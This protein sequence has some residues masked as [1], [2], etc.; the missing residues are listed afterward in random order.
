MVGETN[1]HILISS[2]ISI[3]FIVC[4]LI[5]CQFVGLLDTK[6]KVQQFL[7]TTLYF[8]I[9]YIYFTFRLVYVPTLLY[10]VFQLHGNKNKVTKI[11]SLLHTGTYF[12]SS[13]EPSIPFLGWS[14]HIEIVCL[15]FLSS[16]LILLSWVYTNAYDSHY[17]I[18]C[19]L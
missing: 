15:T 2:L 4:V 5:R 10:T 16:F 3:Q 1:L 11:C 7:L 9:L 8:C 12:M 6:P 13:P 18:I 14:D 19:C 17:F